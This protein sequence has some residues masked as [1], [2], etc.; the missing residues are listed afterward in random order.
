MLDGVTNFTA[1]NIDDFIKDN[2]GIIIVHKTLCPMC[3][4]M[5]KVL[6]KVESENGIKIGSIDSEADAP[7]LERFG[8]DRVPALVAVKGGAV[9][10]THIG[11]LKPNEVVDFFKKA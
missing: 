7:L 3:K 6:T 10:A 9:K 1:A 5:G 2:E 4:V 8:V 11:T